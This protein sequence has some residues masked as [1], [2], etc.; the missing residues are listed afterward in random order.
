MDGREMCRQIK[1]DWKCYG[2]RV[3]V[4]TALYTNYRYQQE[5]YKSFKVDRYMMKPL[6]IDRLSALLKQ[7]LGDRS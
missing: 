2:T 7:E 6:G 1:E 4:M 5:A 3:V